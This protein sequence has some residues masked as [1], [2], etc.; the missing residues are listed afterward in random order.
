MVNRPGNWVSPLFGYTYVPCGGRLA[1]SRAAAGRIA[2]RE[3]SREQPPVSDKVNYV[4]LEVVGNKG[5][6]RNRVRTRRKKQ[7]PAPETVPSLRPALT[8]IMAP[9]TRNVNF[10]TGT[11]YFTSRF[12]PC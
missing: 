10:P 11:R 8:L 7:P 3:Y 6:K 9:P 12:L 5:D 2:S 4:N 1:G